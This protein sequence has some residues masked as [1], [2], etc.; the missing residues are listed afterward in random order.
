[1]NH[2]DQI[3]TPE[4]V[5]DLAAEWFDVFVPQSLSS[6][7]AKQARQHTRR[8]ETAAGP[9]CWVKNRLLDEGYFKPGRQCHDDSVVTAIL[10]VGFLS[11]PESPEMLERLKNETPTEPALARSRFANCVKKYAVAPI[12]ATAGRVSPGDAT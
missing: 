2:H 6:R 8:W 9:V 7:I 5:A 3:L 4:G 10:H 1:M 12:D 11:L